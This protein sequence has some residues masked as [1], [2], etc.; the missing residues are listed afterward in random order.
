MRLLSLLLALVFLV[1]SNAADPASGPLPTR[2][3]LNKASKE[4]IEL[5][6]GVGPKL[7][8]E[9]IL[10]RP[11]RTI[12]DLDKVKGIG[13]KKLQQIRPRV[14][15]AP[16]IDGFV[17][18][19]ATNEVIRININTASQTE[20]EKLNGIGPKKAEAIIAARPFKRPED[21]MRVSGLKRAQFEKIKDQITVR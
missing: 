18:R 11:Y 12:D 15:I 2:I 6:P 7:A 20:L 8:Q 3:D 13:P 1:G 14:F 9:I 5:L 17:P 10:A 21:L 16:M 19:P 4:T